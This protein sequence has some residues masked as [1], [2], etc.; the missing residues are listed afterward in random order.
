[1]EDAKIRLIKQWVK[2]KES[3]TDQ[4]RPAVINVSHGTHVSWAAVIER[5]YNNDKKLRRNEFVNILKE[6]AANRPG[7][8]DGEPLH[9]L[10]Y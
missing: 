10:S 4:R 1:M 3:S 6:I 2:S 7:E 8:Q 5:L 9:E